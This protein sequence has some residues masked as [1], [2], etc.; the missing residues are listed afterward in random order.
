MTLESRDMIA[1]LPSTRLMDPSTWQLI[2][3]LND[4]L[5]R[6]GGFTSAQ[7]SA[8]GAVGAL[9]RCQI[10]ITEYEGSWICQCFGAGVCVVEAS[11]FAIALRERKGKTKLRRSHITDMNRGWLLEVLRTRL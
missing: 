1:V 11:A 5:Q 3:E 8:L 4:S 2:P 6:A 7:I 10:Q 9:A